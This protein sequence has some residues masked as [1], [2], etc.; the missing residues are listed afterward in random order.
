MLNIVFL[1]LVSFFTDISTEM[2]YPIVPLYL[3]SVF[4]A[5]PA[6]VGVIE[7]IAES[8]ASLLK[9]FSGHITDRFQKKKAT[10]FIGYAPGV[11][12]KFALLFAASWIGVLGARVLDRIG[13]G[14][15][16]VPRDVLISENAENAGMG[17]AFGIHKALDMSGAAL[18]ILIT[19]F[20]LQGM[21]ENFDYKKMFMF[22]IIPAIVGL[23]MF[24]FIREKREKRI[25]KHREPFWKNIRSIDAQLRLYLV[26]VF[27][28]TL[29]N[30]SNAFIILKA[31]A[32]GFDAAKVILLYFFY[33]VTASVLS[34]PCGKLS[35]R[36]G[37]KKLLVP[38]Y[39]A[40]SLCYL[41][42]AFASNQWML[43]IVFF[44]YGVYTAM[45]AGVERAF[46][47][48]ISPPELKGTMLGL[49][50][51][52]AGVALLPASLIAG[53]LWNAFGAGVPFIFGASLSLLAAIVLLVFMKNNSTITA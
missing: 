49:H 14:I 53:V 48:E 46:I 39:I 2:V 9:V 3:T 6:L 20:A 15:R 12:Y 29:G 7:G 22:S 5:T 27:L 45:I 28:F 52:V 13:K 11:L 18:G 40:F 25:Q 38:G 47:A 43:I 41:G 31:N 24:F 1:G 36:I 26:V 10:A 34:I 44:M 17:K 8:V 19:Y 21:R 37:R 30:S 51:T 4:G 23:C 50:S 32:I 35:D 33:N 42:F 16:T